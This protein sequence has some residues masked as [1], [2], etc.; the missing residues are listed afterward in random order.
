MA[1]RFT[2]IDTR[3]ELAR[4]ARVSHGTISKVRAIEEKANPEQKPNGTT[5]LD[6]VS[7]PIPL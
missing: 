6:Q 3:E 4:A 2:P 5:Y 7:D 1:E